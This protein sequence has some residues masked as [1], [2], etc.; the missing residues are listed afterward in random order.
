MLSS[1]GSSR[2]LV[3]GLALHLRERGHQRGVRQ[4]AIFAVGQKRVVALEGLHR[5]LRFRAE[6]PVRPA[7]RQG[8]AQR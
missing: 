6:F 1:G 3:S 8:V 2:L 5:P 7:F 4:L